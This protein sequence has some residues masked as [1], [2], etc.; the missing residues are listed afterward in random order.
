MGM[1]LCLTGASAIAQGPQPVAEGY[2]TS[3]VLTLKGMVRLSWYP[4][5]L[6]P[7]CLMMEVPDANGKPEQWIIG[8]HPPRVLQRS[9]WNPNALR[10]VVITLS[11]YRPKPGSKAAEALAD[12]V[13]ANDGPGGFAAELRKKDARHA[14]GFEVTLPDGKKMA[15]GE[16]H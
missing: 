14:Y 16:K 1:L 5:A 6:V 10:D 15:F 13:T 3:T 7:S 2:D 8:G 9:G 12:L 11:A 4:P